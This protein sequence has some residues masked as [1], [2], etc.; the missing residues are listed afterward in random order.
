LLPR[1]RGPKMVAMSS[2]Q[3]TPEAVSAAS[4]PVLAIS[5]AVGSMHGL[6]DGRKAVGS[7]IS[8]IS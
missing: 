1:R 7:L 6:G 2:F 3:V 5:A 8:D 4:P